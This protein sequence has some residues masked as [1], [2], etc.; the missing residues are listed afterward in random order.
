M[1]KLKALS[2][3]PV[4]ALSIAGYVWLGYFT[5][6]TDSAQLICLHAGL[7][8]I[9][10]FALSR[11]TFGGSLRAVLG[12]ALLVRLCLLFMTPNLSDDYFR[13]IWDGLVWAG[14]YNPYLFTPSGLMGSGPAVEG[15]NAAMYAGLNSPDFYTAYPPV[16]QFVF[17]AAARL[18]GNNVLPNLVIMRLFIILA[19]AGTIIIAHKL[20]DRLALPGHAVAIYAFNPLVVMELTGNLHFEALML[21]FLLL[22]IYL[23][24]AR[25]Q[26]FAALSFG[27][28][29]GVKLLPLIFLPLLI[30]RL[31]WRGSIKFFAIT[32]GVLAAL[33]LPFY[34]AG[35]VPGYFSTLGLYFQ[36]F[37]FNASV[38]Y[39]LRW[40]GYALTGYNTIKTLGIILALATLAAIIA[41]AIRE[42]D[43]G[44]R[45]LMRGMLLC[46]SAYY[47]LATTVHPW[48]IAPLVLL[49]LFTDL[50]Y[51]VAW[52]VLIIVSYTAYRG[53][54]YAENLWLVALE[55]V[56]VAGFAVW[57]LFFRRE[58]WNGEGMDGVEP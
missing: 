9:Y 24:A 7:C 34:D 41:I 12:G 55:Y 2:A 40:A 52:S 42:K 18:A 3:A 11:R 22:S 29:A 39:L 10:L 36:K 57:E 47:L 8:G 19:E 1:Q 48:Y 32:G 17:G 35:L 13:F 49:C 45:A 25:K 43:T 37:E 15:L 38:Y 50:R 14:G 27:V 20:L 4:L 58:G 53:T 28:A 5:Q 30:R 31:G 44:W 21:F 46:I 26:H 33:F 54:P 6:R 56:A 23:L 16:C 51:P